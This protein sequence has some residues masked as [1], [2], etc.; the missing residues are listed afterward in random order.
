MMV[1]S[2]KLYQMQEYLLGKSFKQLSEGYYW[3]V[4]QLLYYLHSDWLVRL[5]AVRQPEANGAE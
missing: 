2:L 1:C 5:S 3:K 4:N